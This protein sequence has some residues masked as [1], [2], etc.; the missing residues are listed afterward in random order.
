MPLPENVSITPLT[1]HLVRPLASLYSI[2]CAD[3]PGYNAIFL[4]TGYK[5]TRALEWFFEK[6][7]FI[8]LKRG[9]YIL[10]AIDNNSG[11]VVGGVGL[12]PP[13]SRPQL[14]DKL[15][16]TISWLCQWGLSSFVRLL[17]LDKLASSGLI[18]DG[19]FELIMMAVSEKY[20]KNG[21]G[22]AL[23][24]DALR[25]ASIGTK[26]RLTT[27]KLTNVQYYEKFK[28]KLIVRQDIQ[29][30]D[31]RCES[32]SQWVMEIEK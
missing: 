5:K 26:V 7:L 28:F 1:F 4:L 32:F 16:I 8:L 15:S 12:V 30:L 2:V 24:H 11:D 20:R 3:N 21:I 14:V 19:E 13:T 6:R 23:V 25:L 9:A 22:A 10:V 31:K 29:L 18:G 27:N 17:E